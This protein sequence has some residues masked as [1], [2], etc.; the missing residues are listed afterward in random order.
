DGYPD[1]L[2]YVKT[3]RNVIVTRSFSKAYS[4]AGLRIGYGVAPEALIGAMNKVREPFN[5]NSLAQAA[6]GA[7]LKDMAFVKRSAAS[8]K[9][10][11]EFLYDRLDSLNI[12]YVPSATNFILLK[13]GSDAPGIYG[14]L[15]NKGVIVRNMS[16]WGLKNC[17]RVTVGTMRENERFLK[18]LRQVIRRV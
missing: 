6:A 5:V 11:K 1:T 3:K 12:E 10:G 15:L 13:I 2:K 17:L 7:A 9:S 16:S 8:V 14:R 4:L 18:T